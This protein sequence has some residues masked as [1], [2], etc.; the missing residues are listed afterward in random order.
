MRLN[1]ISDSDKKA[2][3][4][5]IRELM[6]LIEEEEE[7]PDAIVNIIFIDDIRMFHLNRK[8]RNKSGSTDVLSF[9]IDHDT[10]V[11]SVLGEIYI[12]TDTAGRNAA[13]NNLTFAAETLRLCCHGFLHLLGY[14]H[15]KT[16]DRMVMEE[17]ENHYLEK[18]YS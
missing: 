1:I 8:F 7:P 4:K 17:K 6:A 9:N 11:D 14:D 15:T 13:K 3:L 12:S 5:K 10:D 16:K 18:F 2:P